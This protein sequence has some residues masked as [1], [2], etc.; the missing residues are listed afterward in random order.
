MTLDAIHVFKLRIF[1]LWDT[2]KSTIAANL[3]YVS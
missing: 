1:D 3:I 2:N